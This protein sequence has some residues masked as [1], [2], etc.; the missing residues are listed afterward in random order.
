MD[1]TLGRMLKALDRTGLA[2]NTIVVFT[3]DH[4]DNLGSLGLVQKGGPNEE[5]IRIQLIMRGPGVAAQGRAVTGHVGSLVDLAPTLLSLA[6]IDTPAHF[7]GRDLS[8]LCRGEA[9]DARPEAYIEFGGGAAIRSLHHTYFLPFAKA[10][11]QL[12]DRPQQFYDLA[13]DPFQLSNLAGAALLPEPA[14]ELDQWLREWHARTPWMA[15]AGGDGSA[16]V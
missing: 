11:H 6:G 16:E 2:G 1:D 14:E 10:G 15:R 8:A 13:N 7:H 3:S 5:S 4:G 12:A 9:C